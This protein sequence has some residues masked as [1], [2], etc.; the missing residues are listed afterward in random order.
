MSKKKICSIVLIVL[1]LLFTSAHFLI[2]EEKPVILR[3]GMFSD[4]N[5]NAKSDNTARILEVAIRKFEKIHPEVKISVET[6]IRKKDYTEW[7]EGEFLTGKEPDVFMVPTDTFNVLASKGALLELE[8]FMKEDAIDKS[9]FYQAAIISGQYERKQYALPYEAVP[10][11]MRVNTSLLYKNDIE[12][13]ENNWTWGDFHAICRKVTKD[14]N[15]DGR[16]DQFGVYNYTWKD[17]SYSNGAAL[18]S[19]NGL[20]N[21]VSNQDVINAVKFFYKI[22]A[23][24]DGYEVSKRD[25]EMGNVVFSPMLLTDYRTYNSYPYKIREYSDFSWT[26]ITMPAGPQGDNSSEVDTLLAAIAKR[27]H[28]K[29]LAWEFL[30]LL[31]YDEEIQRMVACDSKGV[32]VLKKVTEDPGVY[33]NVE[34]D[35]DLFMLAM[36]KGVT[37]PK[38][39][40]YKDA[41]S[42]MNEGVEE[43]MNSDMDIKASLM[44]LQKK[45]DSFLK[46]D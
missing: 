39:S 4:S 34:I 32:S 30:K 3:F 41:V 14:N 18:F 20:E 8:K 46:N 26:C 33:K 24:S 21:H 28:N 2:K 44:T 10:L 5:W 38:F 22:N 31:T 25:F 1:L 42:M 43:A 13:P 45:I 9:G 27:S 7:L 17:A 40:K 6:G 37:V 12:V 11:L 23:L 19:E 16:L 35:T 15:G 29:Q 36:E